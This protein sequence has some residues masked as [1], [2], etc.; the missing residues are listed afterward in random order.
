MLPRDLARR[1][2]VVLNGYEWSPEREGEMASTIPYYVYRLQLI[3]APDSA[4]P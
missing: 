2:H 3:V 4:D 1:H